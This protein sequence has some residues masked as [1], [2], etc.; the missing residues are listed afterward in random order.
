GALGAAGLGGGEV[1]GEQYGLGAAAGEPFALRAGEGVEE[2]LDEVVQDGRL[3]A[4]AGGAGECFAAYG[5]GRRDVG[6]DAVAPLAGPGRGARLGAASAESWVPG[7]DGLCSVCGVHG[8][9]SLPCPQ[10]PLLCVYAP[11]YAGDSLPNVSG[12]VKAGSVKRVCVSRFGG[13]P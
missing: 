5:Q 2:V 7:R 4:L 8:A 9:V 10:R 13:R 6:Q 11:V 3:V 12:P 1:P